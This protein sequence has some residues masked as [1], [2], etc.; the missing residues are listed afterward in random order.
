MG[1]EKIAADL[2][3][4]A[5]ELEAVAQEYIDELE[6]EAGA[7]ELAAKA[8]GHAKRF[9]ELLMGGKKMNFATGSKKRAI[10]KLHMGKRP[11]NV[12]GGY[13][14]GEHGNPEARKEALKSLAARGGAALGLT[15]AA[16]TAHKKHSK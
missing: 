14:P 12:A 6:K 3:V 4:D 10:D 2:G 9:G 5:D 8:G 1:I 11:G 15:A 7:K 13:K 16:R